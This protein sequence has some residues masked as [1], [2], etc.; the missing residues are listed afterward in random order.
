MRTL[1]GNYFP[2]GKA[3]R[4]A[5][6]DGFADDRLNH[7]LLTITA[8][9][10]VVASGLPRIVAQYQINTNSPDVDR[11]LFLTVGGVNASGVPAGGTISYQYQSLGTAGSNDFDT[12]V[13]QNT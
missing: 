2:H 8:P 12:A 5:Y 10:E 7:N 1:N 13:F 11:L 3:W 4:Y 9:N 6:S